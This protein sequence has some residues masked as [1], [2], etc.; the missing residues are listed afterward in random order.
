MQVRM[1]TDIVGERCVFRTGE[2]HEIDDKRGVAWCKS[3]QATPLAEKRVD[4][5]ERRTPKRKG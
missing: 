3:G 1:L 2:V 4:R 5:A